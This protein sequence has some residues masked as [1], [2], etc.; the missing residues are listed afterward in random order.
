MSSFGDFI[1]LSEKCDE[2]T[3]KIINREVS[4]GIVAPS[5]EPA[6]LSLLAKKKNG[7]YCVLKVNP[8]YVP[9]ETEERSVFGLKLRQKRNNAVINATTFINVVGKHNNVSLMPSFLVVSETH[10]C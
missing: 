1:A 2:L 7:N 8:N 4:D 10:V 5:Y 6:A 3:A 9:T